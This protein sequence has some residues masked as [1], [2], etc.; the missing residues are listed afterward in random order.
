MSRARD[1]AS[2]APGTSGTPFRIASGVGTVSGSNGPISSWYYSNAITVTLPVGRFS[3]TPIITITSVASGAVGA[4]NISDVSS[5]SFSYYILR[6]NASPI[7]SVNWTA[8][9][10]TSGAASG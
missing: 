6:L 5:S 4:S 1:L 7:G 10:M 9:Q 2:A 3:T 8:I